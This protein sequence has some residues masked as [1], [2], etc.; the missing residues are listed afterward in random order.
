MNQ[1]TI[2]VEPHQPVAE[3]RAPRPASPMTKEFWK[4]CREDIRSNMGWTRPGARAMLAYRFGA[5]ALTV[6]TPVLGALLR[7]LALAMHRYIRN[8]YGIEIY[9]TAT[10]GQRVTIGH[11]SGIVI[12]EYAKIGDDCLIRQ[13][14]TMGLANAKGAEAAPENAPTIGS[15]VDIGVGAV[16]MGAVTIG[17]D[18]TIFPNAVVMTN[19]PP[20]STVIS[21]VSRILPRS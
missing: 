4:L 11:Q 16:I 2:P 14:V 19:V 20:R 9:P 15:R 13:G 10:I 1:H 18:V 17:D 12:H 7:R 6:R 21:P 3:A 5:W 8:S